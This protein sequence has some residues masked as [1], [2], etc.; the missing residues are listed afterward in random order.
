[1]GLRGPHA[2]GLISRWRT[3]E[4]PPRKRRC[5]RCN[6]LFYP[7]RRDA[8]YCSAACRQAI[9]WK[10]HLANMKT[11]DRPTFVLVLR[12]EKGI[13]GLRATKGLQKF[14]LRKFGLR[15][16]TAKEQRHDICVV[17]GKLHEVS[18]SARV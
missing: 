11:D 10:R 6:E 9:Y 14:A 15:V 1:M 2:V 18:Q 3:R 16:V 8:V 7:V 5:R 13:D 12:P 17:D 4:K